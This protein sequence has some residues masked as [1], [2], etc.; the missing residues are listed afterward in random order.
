MIFLSRSRYNMNNIGPSTDP[1]GSPWFTLEGSEDSWFTWTN[2]YLSDKYDLNHQRVV[3]LMSTS[4]SNLYRRMLW[5]IVSRSNRTRTESSPWSVANNRSL[6]TKDG[7]RK[8]LLVKEP[9]PTVSIPENPLSFCKQFL[10]LIPIEV[11]DVTH[12]LRKRAKTK[13]YLHITD[14]NCKHCNEVSSQLDVSLSL[15]ESYFEECWFCWSVFVDIFKIYTKN[16]F[17]TYLKNLIFLSLSCRIRLH[18]L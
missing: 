15:A 7:N 13:K 6:V 4:C 17:F 14:N 2:W 10:L 18:C 3:P 11:K 8:R 5:S 1:C 12:T 16:I 9:V